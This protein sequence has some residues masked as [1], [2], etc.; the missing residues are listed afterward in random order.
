MIK[1]YLYKIRSYI[2]NNDKGLFV[3]DLCSNTKNY[4]DLWFMYR[5]IFFRFQ[6][7]VLL[8]KIKDSLDKMKIFGFLMGKKTNVWSTNKFSNE[9]HTAYLP[10][11]QKGGRY[12]D[13]K[14]QCQRT[15]RKV[16]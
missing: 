9:M 15:L 14:P 6:S 13:R 2:D 8:K 10:Q 7:L 5:I 11:C 3:V 16:L 12:K 4:H 1:D